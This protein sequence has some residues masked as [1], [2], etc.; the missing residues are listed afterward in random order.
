[1]NERVRKQVRGRSKVGAVT[2]VLFTMGAFV[3]FLW[4]ALRDDL[5]LVWNNGRLFVGI[6]MSCVGILSYASSTYC[7]GT[8]SDHYSCTRPSTYYYY[9]WW[10][11]ALVTFGSF[12]IV[13]WFLRKKKR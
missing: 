4:D 1:M 12:F 13:L 11:I 3:L 2:R 7:D 8:V 5:K 6:A 9:P 10:A